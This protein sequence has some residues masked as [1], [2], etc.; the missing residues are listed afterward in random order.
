M[1]S[2]F[3]AVKQACLS[4]RLSCFYECIYIP[5]YYSF[6][7][8]QWLKQIQTILWINIINKANQVKPIGALNTVSMAGNENNQVWQHVG[9]ETM[10]D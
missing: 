5:E 2:G 9:S 1:L 4:L 3:Q 8:L 10:L 6:K 7:S